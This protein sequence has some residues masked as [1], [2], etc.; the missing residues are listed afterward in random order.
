MVLHIGVEHEGTLQLQAQPN[1]F[2]KAVVCFQCGCL[3]ILK[4]LFVGVL[5]LPGLLFGVFIRATEV[6][7]APK[8]KAVLEENHR[9]PSAWCYCWRAWMERCLKAKRK[10]QIRTWRI[11]NVVVPYS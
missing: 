10:A 7:Q 11:T 4:V 3:H 1:F 2:I 8:G 6:L 5:I 9:I